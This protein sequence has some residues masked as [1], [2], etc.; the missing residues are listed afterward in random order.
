MTGNSRAPMPEPYTTEDTGYPVG[1][2][3]PGQYFTLDY[4]DWM[5]AGDPVPY[6]ERHFDADEATGAQ[7]GDWN[8]YTVTTVDPYYKP[9][10]NAWV[11]DP[12]KL[13]DVS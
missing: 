13:K 6:T 5:H 12:A 3:M 10:F 7:D 4:L 2:W 8:G 1:V 9:R 11:G